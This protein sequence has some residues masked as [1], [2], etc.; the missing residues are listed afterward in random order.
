MLWLCLM[1][2][3]FPCIEGSLVQDV[4]SFVQQGGSVF[5][6]LS[7]RD[8]IF[9]LILAYF[10]R[11]VLSFQC[12]TR[13]A[14]G[15]VRE[16]GLNFLKGMLGEAFLDGNDD[17]GNHNGNHIATRRRLRWAQLGKKV[18]LCSMLIHELV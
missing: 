9:L 16:R 17:N 1:F 5:Q 18:S 15:A 12:G 7:M 8:F 14:G 3:A 11:P 6:Y 4:D 13:G 10:L 2:I